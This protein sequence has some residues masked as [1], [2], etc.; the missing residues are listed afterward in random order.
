LGE[1]G[2]IVP[3]ALVSFRH[4][5][6]VTPAPSLVIPAPLSCHSGESRNPS[7]ELGIPYETPAFQ[8]V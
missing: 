2:A 7:C 6:L 1:G 4:P 5:S 8:P 3:V